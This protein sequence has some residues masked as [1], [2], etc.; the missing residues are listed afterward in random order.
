[1]VYFWMIVAG[2][3]VCVTVAV[4]AYITGRR[5]GAATE[6]RVLMQAWKVTPGL[7]D[8]YQEAVSFIAGAVRAAVISDITAPIE[9]QTI[10][11]PKMRDRAR[12]ILTRY[13]KELSK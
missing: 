6:A 7:L 10:L 1:M 9:E 13:E 4:T 12:S 11:P 3:A 5:V 2:C 8:V